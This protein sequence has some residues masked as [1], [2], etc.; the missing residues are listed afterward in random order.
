MYKKWV[1]EFTCSVS[2]LCLDIMVAT[3]YRA[4]GYRCLGTSVVLALS[5]FLTFIH[6]APPSNMVILAKRKVA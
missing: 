4:A 3:A 6:S 5:K 2:V 1:Y